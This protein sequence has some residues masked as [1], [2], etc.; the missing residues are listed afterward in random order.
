[1]NEDDVQVHGPFDN[2]FDA[3]GL[4]DADVRQAKNLAQLTL[5]DAIEARGLSQRE[6]AALMGVSQPNLARTLT[7]SC[8][9]L[10]WDQLFKLW[11]ALGGNVQISFLPGAG[12]GTGHVEAEGPGLLL[13]QRIAPPKTRPQPAP[14]KARTAAQRTRS[15]TTSGPQ[16]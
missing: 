9:S 14:K 8:S 15:G 1:L 7:K 10:T 2:V 4:P 13:P 12:E 5:R 6:A 16:A 11:T 3:L